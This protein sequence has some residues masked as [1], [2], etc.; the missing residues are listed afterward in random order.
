MKKDEKMVEKDELKEV[1]QRKLYNLLKRRGNNFIL[2]KDVAN[3]LPKYYP[4]NDIYDFHNSTSRMLM[5]RDIQ[6]IND[7]DAFEKIIISSTSGI[8]LSTKREFQSYINSQYAAAFA[9]LKRVRRKSEK[10]ARDGQYVCG[11]NL[12]DVDHIVSAFIDE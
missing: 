1:R 8:K 10:G 7:S 9:K 3:L 11:V 2:Q 12:D 4:Y 6:E 5:T